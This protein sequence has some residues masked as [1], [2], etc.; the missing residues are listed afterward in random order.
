MPDM[1]YS[2]VCS[3]N[4][5]L[6]GVAHLPKPLPPA[7][8]HHGHH[9][10]HTKALATTANSSSATDRQK[11]ERVIFQAV[12]I[13]SDW[14]AAE[15]A[16]IDPQTA[17]GDKNM[18]FMDSVAQRLRAFK[19]RID[20]SV[21]EMLKN[22]RAACQRTPADEQPRTSSCAPS[23]SRGSAKTPLLLE[24]ENVPIRVLSGTVKSLAKTV[25]MCCVE[26][27]KRAHA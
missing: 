25:S 23:S 5:S 2:F 1:F 8:V 21:I 24:H 3:D 14:M 10:D 7:H 20:P 12:E 13:I 18:K 26:G 16:F 17:Y 19:A 6:S 15:P 22:A 9:H 4:V 27:V 11:R